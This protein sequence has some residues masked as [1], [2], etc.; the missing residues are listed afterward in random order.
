MIV[1]VDGVADWDA[2]TGQQ[3]NDSYHPSTPVFLKQLLKNTDPSA[4][5]GNEQI[6]KRRKRTVSKSMFFQFI[7]IYAYVLAYTLACM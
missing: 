1:Y 3:G 2:T 4:V 7:N 6:R 5:L